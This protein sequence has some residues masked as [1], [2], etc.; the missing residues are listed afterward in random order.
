MALAPLRIIKRIYLTAISRLSAVVF[1]WNA[2]VEA[3]IFSVK[4]IQIIATF[5]SPL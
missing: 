4:I 5:E 2:T 3:G 1:D